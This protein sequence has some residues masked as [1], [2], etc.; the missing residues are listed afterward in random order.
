M[1]KL[2]VGSAVKRTPREMIEH[3]KRVQQLLDTEAFG[4]V[5]TDAADAIVREWSGAKTPD[6]REQAHAKLLGLQQLVAQLQK[7][8]EDGVLAARREGGTPE[9]QTRSPS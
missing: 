3:G 1:L 2:E 8:V 4:V 6:A 9:H 7:A 5:V